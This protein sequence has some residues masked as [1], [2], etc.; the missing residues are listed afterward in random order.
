MWW[1]AFINFR[2]S[3]IKSFYSFLLWPK[4]FR[5][6]VVPSLQ[7]VK[8]LRHDSVRELLQLVW[9][10]RRFFW[11]G[12]LFFLFR[13]S[14]VVRNY[15]AKLIR[16]FLPLGVVQKQMK[17]P[18]NGFVLHVNNC[19]ENQFSTKKTPS[20]AAK[21]YFSSRTYRKLKTSVSGSRN[22]AWFSKRDIRLLHYFKT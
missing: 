8:V 4:T 10:T 21:P 11:F 18:M 17:S 20:I 19:L 16:D 3:F 13:S 22:I 6:L 5:R 15:Q 1:T 2:T 9:L 14:G 7:T 12:L